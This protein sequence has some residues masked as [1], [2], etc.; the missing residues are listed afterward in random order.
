MI[1]KLFLSRGS[2]KKTGIYSKR[3]LSFFLYL[4]KTYP[5]DKIDPLSFNGKIVKMPSTIAY[6]RVSTDKQDLR[7]QKFGLLEYCANKNLGH[8]I[9]IEEIKSGRFHW[10][11]RKLG[12]ALR[13][14]NKGDIIVTSEIS[15]LG[16]SAYQV[17]EFLEE[18]AKKEVYVHIVKNNMIM[19]NSIQSTIM[20][21]VLGLAA[22]I[23]REFFSLRI[24]ESLKKAKESGKK[25]GR[26][27]GSSLSLKLD[28]RREEIEG[29]LKKGVSKCSISKIVECAPSTLYSWL[30]KRR[31]KNK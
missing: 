18:A 28:R 1:L 15:R 13:H 3:C 10:R 30:K 20:A 8:I 12:N 26:P 22:E 14:C 19:D 9:F 11:E 17:L 27:T 24:K 29:Y 6:L 23:E 21:T 2:S 5:F 4:F 25:L 7:N 16:R 31:I